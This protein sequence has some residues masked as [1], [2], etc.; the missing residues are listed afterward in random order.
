MG[1]GPESGD[2]S[3][4][5]FEAV[6]EAF[7][8]RYFAIR[9]GKELAE[10]ITEALGYSGACFCEVFT[11][12]DQ[13]WEPKNSAR[14]EADGRLTSRPLEDLAPFLPREELTDNMYI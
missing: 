6:A 9:Q 12:T 5:R 10:K 4:P 11:D 2:L 7:G 3:F 13:V 14:R 8:Y 1:I